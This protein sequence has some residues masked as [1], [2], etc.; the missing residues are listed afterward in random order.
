MATTIKEIAQL[1]GV[2]IG[3][4]DRALHNRGRVDP[5]VAQR[6]RKIAKE[7]DYKPN[8]I[9]QGLSARSRRFRIAAVFHRKHLDFFF[10]DVLQ[11]IELCRAEASEASVEVD[12]FYSEDFS[13]ESQLELL[14]KVEQEQY[15][16]LIVVPINHDAVKNRINHLSQAGIPVILLTNI[17]DGC[18]FLSFIGCNYTQS[19]QIAAGLLNMI[20]PTPGKLLYL[21]PSF[22]MLGH[23]LRVNGLKEQL[24]KCYPQ[25][26]LSEVCELAGSDIKDYKITQQA[27]KRRPDIDLIV[28]PGAGSNGHIEAI[29]EFSAARQIKVISYDYSKNTDYYIRNKLITATLI[30]HPRQ[31][32]YLAVKT[33]VSRL[34]NPRNFSVQTFQYLPT[35]IFFLENLDNVDSWYV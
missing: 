12:L 24:R 5:E 2:S 14:E 21:S 26:E 22:Q 10:H 15:N 29:E 32:G 3:T 28:C 23:I 13:P 33:A 16:A 30:Q 9:A 25:I 6:I 17:I 8:S 34:L 35:G 19:G 18:D 4:V 1:A 7:L 11:G 20:H 31:Q 27:L